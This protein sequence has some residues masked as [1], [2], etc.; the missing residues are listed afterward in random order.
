MSERQLDHKLEI[1]RL[2]GLEQ[3][4]DMASEWNDLTETA[5]IENLFLTHD[6]LLEWWRV[7]GGDHE[8][9][10]LT[11]R[12]QGSLRGIAPLMLTRDP[13]GVRCITFIGTGE[14]TPD[15]LDFIVLSGWRSEFIS[16]LCKYLANS[17]SLWDIL[18]CDCFTDDSSVRE[19]LST[20]LR[21]QG[22]NVEYHRTIVC[23]Y[24]ILPSTF[25]VFLQSRG[26][27]TRQQ[28]RAKLR[29]L[30]RD[31]PE[32]QFG[33]VESLPQFDE[34]F[35][36]LIRLH[37]S[38]WMGRGQTGS[39]A[40]QH[41]IDFHRAIASDALAKGRLRLYYLKIEDSIV[42]TYYCFQVGRKTTYY[43]AGFDDKWHQYSI[44]ILIMAYAIEQSIGQGSVEF[45]FLQGDEEY[46]SHW[47]THTRWDWSL[48]AP[49]GSRRGQWIWA[50]MKVRKA[51]LQWGHRYMPAP[52][53]RVSKLLRR[54]TP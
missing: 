13:S 37:Q 29:R 47:S 25:E 15:Q 6:W 52:L 34:A 35:E 33:R 48:R 44:G 22:L 12:F 17:Q 41:I 36:A 9:W 31:H 28:F 43:N 10:L 51:V 19:L 27:E 11:G 18:E 14:I 5:H 53:K 50:Q 7:Y 4:H 20:S 1:A 49:S 40:D 45:D 2:D 54:R 42:A 38:R 32:A 21:K 24:S 16:A 23:P 26:S 30:I 3:L 8:L 46:K 39:F